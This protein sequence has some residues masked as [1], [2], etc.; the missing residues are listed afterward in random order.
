MLKFAFKYYYYLISISINL[1]VGSKNCAWPRHKRLTSADDLLSSGSPSPTEEGG[2]EEKALPSS[3]DPI[4][5]DL[6]QE[7]PTRE[8]K[9]ASPKESPKLSL[10]GESPMLS[11]FR[12]LEISSDHK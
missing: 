4:V 5:V 8:T 9:D 1:A 10:V 2:E 7:E 12:K 11:R 3:K 6:K